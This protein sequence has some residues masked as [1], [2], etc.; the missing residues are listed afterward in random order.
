MDKAMMRELAVSVLDAWNTQD[1]E[2][3]AGCYTEDVQYLDPNT[4]GYANGSEELK[5]YLGKLFEAWQMT[6]AY[7]EGFLFEGGD[8]CAVL[9]HATIRKHGSEQ[10]V[11]FDGMDLVLVRDDKIARNEVYF[12]RA[13]LAA[14]FQGA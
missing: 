12:D 9:W 3:V 7:K 5:R 13:A 8:G 2:A 4:R 6:W 1:V 11:E 10:V 14:L